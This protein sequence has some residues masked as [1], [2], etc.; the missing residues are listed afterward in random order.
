ML[1]SL[2]GWS[3][4]D[5]R[6]RRRSFRIFSFLQPATPRNP[7]TMRP[8]IALHIVASLL[9]AIQVDACADAFRT[10]FLLGGECARG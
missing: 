6:D 3:D 9:A 5:G 1:P 8:R 2:D 7:A 10:T 4:A